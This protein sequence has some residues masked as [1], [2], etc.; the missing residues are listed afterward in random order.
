MVGWN[1][2][3]F[4]A[5]SFAW[6]GSSNVLVMVQMNNGSWSSSIQW[7]SHNPGFQA[8]A[9]VYQDNTPYD[10]QT[11]TY[12]MTTSSTTRANTL[13]KSEGRRSLPGLCTSTNNPGVNT[14][15]NLNRDGWMYY[16]NG[17][18]A[19]NVGAGGDV[20]W[21]TMFPASMITENRLTK[22]ALYENSNNVGTITLNVYSGGDTAPGTQIYSQNITPVGGDAFHEIT[23][24]SP[25]TIDP[26]QNLWI[27]FHQAGDAYPATACKGE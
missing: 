13:F 11:T 5:G 15:T 19:T 24:A 9:Y 18:Y 8:S 16:D 20:Y 2:F 12:S 10:A 4:N 1:E 14:N 17:T 25:V 7:Q 21:G 3:V 22:V 6:D 27:V 23:L 26:S